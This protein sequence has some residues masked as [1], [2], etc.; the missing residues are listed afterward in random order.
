MLARADGY[1]ALF[2]VEPTPEARAAAIRLSI[3]IEGFI[4]DRKHRGKK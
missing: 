4:A 1:C 3:V 2:G